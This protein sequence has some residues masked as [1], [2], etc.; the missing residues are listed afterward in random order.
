MAQAQNQ[1]PNEL[2]ARGPNNTVVATVQT[3]GTAASTHSQL[4]L[5]VHGY[6][7][8]VQAATGSYNA[9]LANLQAWL[10][11]NAPNRVNLDDVFLFFWPGD[12]NWGPLSF[13]SYPLEI[14][15][16]IQSAASLETYLSGLIGPNGLTIDLFVIAHSLGNR[17]L[18]ELLKNLASLGA[19]RL[20]VRYVCLMA[21]AVP[22]AM[23]GTGGA[24][25]AAARSA[26]A[27]ILYSTS[28]LVLEFGF[29]LGETL[30]GEG[31]F[32]EAV[33]RHGNPS[34]DWTA[35]QQMK[36]YGHHDYW[37]NKNTPPQVA[38]IFG[39]VLPNQI[40]QSTI[41]PRQLPPTLQPAQSVTPS[42]TLPAQPS[43]G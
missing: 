4:I 21:A 34:A 37:T 19:G 3:S 8:T 13:G 30:A 9:F 10:A 5:L 23:V 39:V 17:L 29:P 38:R 33:G 18:I 36:S 41:A 31:H 27:L 12:K 42:R 20:Q 1:I 43:F 25:Q 35:T 2:S 16:A 6:D 14:P 24:L 22:V 40:S 28:D 11:Q 7:N 32:P 26:N 15:P